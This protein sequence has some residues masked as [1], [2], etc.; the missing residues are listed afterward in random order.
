M[1][2]ENV[3]DPN[4]VEAGGVIKGMNLLPMDTVFQGNKIRTRV[5]G[6]FQQVEGILADLSGEAVEGYEIHMGISNF[7]EELNPMTSVSN[8]V[9]GEEKF[10]GAYRG[11]IYGSYIHGIFDKEQIAAKVISCLAKAKNIDMEQI[12]SRD[13]LEHKELQYNILADTLRQ[14]L[15]MPEIYAILNEGIA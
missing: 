15:H 3:S 1:L 5:V 8:I 4:G 2:G 13:Y 7:R 9:D 12:S 6:C 10:D 14:H 11:N